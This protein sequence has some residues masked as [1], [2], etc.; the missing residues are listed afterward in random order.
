MKNKF[1]I[2]TGLLLS[3]LLMFAVFL[4]KE[5]LDP[6]NLISLQK[7][8]FIMFALAFIQ[9]MGS[10]L[11][12]FLGA[13]VGSVMSGFLGGLISS[14]VTTANLAK[15]SRVSQDPRAK[16]EVLIFLAATFAMLLEGLILIFIGMEQK[17]PSLYWLLGG[18]SLMCFS[19]VL[20]KLKDQRSLTF[21]KRSLKE[22]VEIVPLIQLS[23]FIIGILSLSKILQSFFGFEALMLLTFLV[24]LFEVHG[25]IVANIQL[26]NNNS[27]TQLDFSHL[28]A[29]STLASYASK[30]FLVLTLGSSALKKEATKITFYL[31]ISLFLSW[32]AVTQF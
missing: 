17:A 23:A 1:W 8:S 3:I 6:W 28:M 21:H 2:Q 16:S 31:L 26:Y 20:Y 9:I 25:S 15:S 19:L 32:F 10:V 13:R 22:K 24:S 29:L 11:I 18:P 7:I 12:H 14:T 30:Y 5:P 27:L 4:P